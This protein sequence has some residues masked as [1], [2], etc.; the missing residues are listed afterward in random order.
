MS[1]RRQARTVGTLPLYIV[2]IT[3]I[4]IF[5]PRLTGNGM[6]FDQFFRRRRPAITHAKVGMEGAEV[7]RHVVADV[8]HQVI[9]HAFQLV[10]AIVRTRYDQVGNL[11]P[12]VGFAFEIDQRIEDRLQVRVSDLV[13][14]LF[15]ESLQVDVGRIHDFEELTASLGS[16]VP[17]G[18]GDGLDALAWQALAESIAYS[19]Q[20]I[21]SL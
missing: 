14:E 21:G 18:D 15:G 12:H 9:A 7:N 3:H 8:L 19:A 17:G 6:S 13:I 11:E 16:D 1:N 5:K 4:Y 10:G 2:H 20:T